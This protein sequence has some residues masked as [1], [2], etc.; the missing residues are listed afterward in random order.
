MFC[1]SVLPPLLFYSFLKSQENRELKK[2][3]VSATI[4]S[5]EKDFN[6]D[7]S[8]YEHVMFP[9]KETGMIMENGTR[10]DLQWSI[11][12]DIVYQ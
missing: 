1:S 11:A 9:F 3:S 2:K 7:I 4:S 6:K 8:F 12:K 10:K 5:F